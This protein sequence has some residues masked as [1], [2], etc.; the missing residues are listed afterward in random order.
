MGV[1]P[2]AQSPPKGR[3][4]GPDQVKSVRPEPVE[5][6]PERGSAN[7]PPNAQ[8]PRQAVQ[9]APTNPAQSILS[10]SKGRQKGPDQVKSVRPK[11]AGG[12]PTGPAKPAPFALS[13]SKGHPRGPQL[14]QREVNL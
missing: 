4:K 8:A 3:Q 9:G 2:F 10:P 7:L 6:P 11:P 12:P 13:L 5:G 14:H 1:P